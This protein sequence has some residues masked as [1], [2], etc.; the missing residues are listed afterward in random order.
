MNPQEDPVRDRLRALYR[1][2]DATIAHH[3]PVCAASGR[4]CRFEEY[5]HTLFLSKPEADLLIDEAPAPSRAL[6]RGESC[7]WQNQR[8]LCTA[9]DAR[10]IGCRVYFCDPKFV[11]LSYEISERAVRVLKSLCEET[12]IGWRYAPL[13]AHLQE[14][15]DAGRIGDPAG[16]PG[17]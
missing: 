8:G 10:P 6:D 4:C 1:A 9:R 17:P 5:G 14:A 12:G 15:A 2:I 11:D 16:P 7:P 3:A 13:H